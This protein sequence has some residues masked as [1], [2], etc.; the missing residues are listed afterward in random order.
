[1]SNLVFTFTPALDE[2]TIDPAVIARAMGYP[3][4]Y[5]LNAL[6]PHIDALLEQALQYICIQSGFRHL[7]S[8]RLENNHLIANDVHFSVGSIIGQ[9][10]PDISSLIIYAATLG[11]KYDSWISQLFSEGNSLDGFIA[12]SLGIVAV[13]A[14][15]EWL[16]QQIEAY[17]A[18]VQLKC[19]YPYSPGQCGWDITEQQVLFHLLPENFC[20][21][22]VTS[23][24]LMIPIKS[25]SGIV[26]MGE[27]VSKK[28][29][30]CN[31]CD[32]TNCHLRR[33]K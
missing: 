30:I 8:A 7:D 24:S 14:A 22:Q 23:S 32:R 31:L 20:G 2:L 9:Q 27:Q 17:G 21:I 28:E 1:M 16:V 26:G 6:F 18:I 3:D 4:I 15:A 13:E 10:L 12:D 33:E 19:T 5:S 29:Y 25:V 11:K